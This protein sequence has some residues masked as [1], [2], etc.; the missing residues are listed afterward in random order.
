MAFTPNDLIS[1]DDEKRITVDDDLDDD[2]SCDDDYFDLD[3]GIAPAN[4][5]DLFGVTLSHLME[6]I[7][8][9]ND[10]INK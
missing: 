1:N 6:E 2:S 5:G 8:D 10:D 7:D 3:E 9:V 4:K